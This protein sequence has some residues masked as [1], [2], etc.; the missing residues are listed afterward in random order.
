MGLDNKIS[1]ITGFTFTAIST[2]SFMGVAQAALIGLVGGFCGMLG[3]EI[4]YYIQK[5]FKK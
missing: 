4:F 5:Q 1:F 2:V 3:K